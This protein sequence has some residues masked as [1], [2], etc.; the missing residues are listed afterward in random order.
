MLIFT[1]FFPSFIIMSNPGTGTWH[2]HTTTTLNTMTDAHV[3]PIFYVV[4]ASNPSTLLGAILLPHPD[5]GPLGLGSHILL[6]LPFATHP[7]WAVVGHRHRR[8]AFSTSREWSC[9][10]PSDRRLWMQ[11][12]PPLQMYCFLPRGYWRTYLNGWMILVS[13]RY[14][15]GTL[16]C[17]Q[18]THQLWELGWSDD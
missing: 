1:F 4:F 17:L 5:D 13:A 6:H 15:L 3:I 12:L 9:Q 7:L 10:H 11:D 18:D 2:L 16:A 8:Y 14:H